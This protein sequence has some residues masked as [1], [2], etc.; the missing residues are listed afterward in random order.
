MGRSRVMQY[1]FGVDDPDRYAAEW[2][3]K[4]GR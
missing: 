3:A 1:Y 2:I 4:L